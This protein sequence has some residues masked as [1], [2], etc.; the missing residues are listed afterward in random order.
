MPSQVMAADSVPPLYL[1]RFDLPA[2][3]SQAGAFALH[4]KIYEALGHEMRPLWRRF[5]DAVLVAAPKPMPGCHAS[6]YGAM[7]RVGHV[8]RFDLLAE[9]SVARRRE[10]ENRGRRVDPILEARLALPRRSYR[11]LVRE[12]ALPWLE[13]KSTDLG[14]EVIAVDQ[15][16]YSPFEII[17]RRKRIR[18][19][20]VR[21]AGELRVID[22][23]VFH[24]AL[25]TGVGHGKAWGCGLLLC[26]TS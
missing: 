8:S 15:I 2:Q 25:R 4:Q 13:R 20:A 22:P 3:R 23:Q 9:I 6:P 16:E 18:I 11:E 10:G 12:I 1:S 7:S 14:F 26:R 24:D 21:F 5:P 19:G 17:R